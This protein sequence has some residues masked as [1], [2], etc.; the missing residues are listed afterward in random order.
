MKAL[1]TCTWNQWWRDMTRFPKQ[2]K[3]MHIPYYFYLACLSP[4]HPPLQCHVFLLLYLLPRLWRDMYTLTQMLQSMPLFCIYFAPGLHLNNVFRTRTQFVSESLPEQNKTFENTNTTTNTPH[5][6]N[7]EH[8]H[9]QL[10]TSHH[11]LR[12]RTQTRTRIE[13]EHEHEQT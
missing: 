2:E 7:P 5:N 13:H 9:E 1:K 10:T 6:I 3:Q 4:T 11:D 12:T 8:E